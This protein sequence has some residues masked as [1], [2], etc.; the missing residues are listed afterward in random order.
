MSQHTT[1]V[2]ADDAQDLRPLLSMLVNGIIP[3]GATEIYKAR[4]TL[5]TMH[6]DDRNVCI[7]AFRQPS[8]PNNYIYTNLRHSKAR[9]SY[10]NTRRL[11]AMGFDAPTP[12]G[13][14]EVTVCHRL[15]ISFYVAEVVAGD[16]MRD[17]QLRDDADELLNDFAAYMVQLHRAGVYHKDFSPGNILVTRD[18]DNRRHFNLIDVNRM[19]FGVHNHT[20]LMRNFKSISLD[21]DETAR[22]A[23]KY[24]AAVG[25]DSETTTAQALAALAAYKATK[26][27]QHKIKALLHLSHHN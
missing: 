25:L 1:I 24:A 27:R 2:T 26:K 15:T 14:A 19:R 12:L 16:T 11:L 21:P 4:N 20:T 9:R 3:E 23:G 8:F 13:Y 5:Y 18:T 6:Y 22:L 10:D 7:K 17:W